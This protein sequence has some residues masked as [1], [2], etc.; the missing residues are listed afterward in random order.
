MAGPNSSFLDPLLSPTIQDDGDAKTRRANI[1]YIGFTVEDD[2]TNDATKITATG[3]GTGQ[4]SEPDNAALRALSISGLAD[5]TVAVVKSPPDTW[6]LTKTTGAGTDDDDRNIIRPTGVLQGQNGRWRSSHGGPFPVTWTGADPSGNVDSAAAFTTA[7]SASRHIVVPPGTYKLASGWAVPRG[8]ITIEL[9]DGAV[10]LCGDAIITDV[11]NVN[12]QGHA[13]GFNPSVNVRPNFVRTG[14]CTMGHEFSR[15]GNSN[16][17]RLDG[18]IW[19][20][21]DGSLSG[22]PYPG[23]TAF[24]I[25]AAGF[26]ASG[27]EW[28][29]FG[30]IDCETGFDDRTNA[31]QNWF[32][33]PV[34][35]FRNG[36]NW[37][38]TALRG[39]SVGATGDTG[40]ITSTVI[41]DWGGSISGYQCGIEIGSEA[42][43]G[44][45]TTV[46][47]GGE[48]LVIETRGGADCH[49][50][51]INIGF[52][53]TV[54]KLHSEITGVAILT[55]TDTTPIVVHCDSSHNLVNATTVKIYGNSKSAVN[56]TFVIAKINATDF[57]LNGTTGTGSGTGTGGSVADITDAHS[58]SIVKIGFGSRVPEAV[59]IVHNWMA[60]PLVQAIKLVNG[61]GC[62]FT[63]NNIDVSAGITTANALKY[64]AGSGR[65]INNVWGPNRKV[66][67]PS[68]AP[69]VSNA[70]DRS[71]WAVVAE[72]NK[73]ASGESRSEML[74]K[75]FIPDVWHYGAAGTNIPGF[76]GILLGESYTINGATNASPIVLSFTG[77]HR[78]RD[79]DQ[80]HVKGV[81]GNTNANGDWTVTYVDRTHV[82]LNASTGNASYTSGG[83]ATV[84][85]SIVASYA[86]NFAITMADGAISSFYYS[87]NAG[88]Y[89]RNRDPA[90]STSQQQRTIAVWEQHYWDTLNN[91]EQSEPIT[92]N[93]TWDDR[94]RHPSY[95]HTDLFFGPAQLIVR[96]DANGI[97]LN[98]GDS[99][100]PAWYR[101][102]G[103]PNFTAPFGSFYLRKDGGAGTTLYVNEGSGTPGNGNNWVG[104]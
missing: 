46:S 67:L 83:T 103:V 82:S 75:R 32:H 36:A 26:G 90:T 40:S 33:Q 95:A 18:I 94:H 78:L 63:D 88:S 45:P 52:D 100:D 86:T 37:H 34:F 53:I 59:D 11:E 96:A 71:A 13:Y 17:S 10:C 80:L 55:A 84:I 22:T 68:I 49:A 97:S 12:W 73:G 51:K 91:T 38:E 21:G 42:H 6:V 50:V 61:D 99:T 70:G 87:D 104:K 93:L 74:A 43:A 101:G 66:A 57:S 102:S 30:G 58:D 31:Q 9:L 98:V 69:E 85:G 89:F 39:I 54:E 2:P 77:N 4:V 64:V 24:A 56:G 15:A 44:Q 48:R 35:G 47:I 92:W 81:G 8:D 14:T 28:W 60:G 1:N 5:G 65:C 79:G 41:G 29:H 72:T 23:F 76:G 20:G 19:D 7:A 62:L 3:G 16:G 25:G 27:F